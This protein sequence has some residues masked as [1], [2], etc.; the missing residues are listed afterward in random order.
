MILNCFV[1]LI[2]DFDEFI[3]QMSAVCD[4]IKEVATKNIAKAQAKQK[5]YYDRRHTIE[6]SIFT[7]H[8][9]VTKPLNLQELKPGTKVL[10][11][12]TL[13]KERKGGKWE[14][15][16]KGPYIIH[17]SLGKGV[18]TLKKMCGDVLKSK[19]NINRLK[20]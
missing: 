11:E 15:L 1:S 5:E 12:N 6:V 13:Q 7:K 3:D 19:H 16:Y 17:E 14:D 9:A 10:V 4:G 18:Y 8:Y 20:V 2:L